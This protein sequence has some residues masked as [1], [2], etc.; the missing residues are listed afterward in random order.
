MKKI[1]LVRHGETDLNVAS[2]VQDGTSQ[3]SERGVAQAAA[4]AVRFREIPARTLIVSDYVRT[5][6]TADP[7]AK[8][9]GLTPEY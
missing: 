1:Y 2:I 7:L 8:V 9:L 5:R 4:L 3:L 6:Q